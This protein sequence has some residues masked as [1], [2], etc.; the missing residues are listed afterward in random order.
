MTAYIL[1]FLAGVIVT[2]LAEFIAITVAAIV[3]YKR[4]KRK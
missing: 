2:V 1:S 4:R 3:S